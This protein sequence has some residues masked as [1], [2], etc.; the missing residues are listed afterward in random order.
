MKATIGLNFNV[1]E[2][3]YKEIVTFA[4]LRMEDV[5][6][7]KH[8]TDCLCEEIMNSNGLE[9]ELSKW[10]KASWTEIY[11]QIF[12]I[13]L[14]LNTY[15]TGQNVI[16]YGYPSDRNIFINTK[17]LSKYTIDDPLDLMEIGSNLLHEHS[18]DCGFDHDFANTRRRKNSISYIMN[19]AYE[20]AY[21]KFYQIP[22]PKP[23]VSLPWWKKVFSWMF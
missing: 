23:I 17:Y 6:N 20:R 11:S 13:T 21:R 19:R 1:F 5:I 3:K 7:S 14:Y 2:N 10:K 8:F 18:H 9:G 12:P 22:E 16:G 4:V 15:Y